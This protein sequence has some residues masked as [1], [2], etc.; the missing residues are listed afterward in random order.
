MAYQNGRGSGC[1]QVCA[2]TT[3]PWRAC[4]PICGQIG[5]LSTAARLHAERRGT[6]SHVDGMDHAARKRSPRFLVQSAH[7]SCGHDKEWASSD[8]KR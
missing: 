6:A 7:C 3:D 8:R 1:E 4:L 2:A 5:E